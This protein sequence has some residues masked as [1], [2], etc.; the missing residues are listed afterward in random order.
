MQNLKALPIEFKLNSLKIVPS[1][2][3]EKYASRNY[4][5]F[6]TNHKQF[7]IKIYRNKNPKINAL[8]KDSDILSTKELTS[9]E[10]R[11]TKILTAIQN[12]QPEFWGV[13]VESWN[14]SFKDMIS[15]S[16]HAHDFDIL[17][18][19]LQ[20]A[21][22][23]KTARRKQVRLMQLT[24]D[25]IVMD[26]SGNFQL[27][28]LDNNLEIIEKAPEYV[29]SYVKY[30]SV[31]RKDSPLAPEVF[32]DKSFSTSS[33]V[34]DLGVLALKIFTAKHPKVDYHAQ[35]VKLDLNVK[36]T[37]SNSKRTIAE[38]IKG[39]LEFHP[40]QRFELNQLILMGQ[41][42]LSQIGTRLRDL[43]GRLLSKMTG[44]NIELGKAISNFGDLVVVDQ[45]RDDRVLVEF[46]P[47]RRITEVKGFT[48][49]KLVKLIVQAGSSMN[50]NAG[51]EL[52]KLAWNEPSSI[53]Q[54]YKEL[55]EK[56]DEISFNE[57]KSMKM[58]L[59][60]YAYLTKAGRNTLLV[61]GKA[62][63]SLNV[64]NLLLEKLMSPNMNNTQSIVFRM[65]HLMLIK[66]NV[67][68]K[69]LGVCEN[70]FAVSKGGLILDYQKLMTPE[71]TLELFDYLNFLITFFLANR[72]FSFDY[73][74]KHCVVT[75]FREI[76][77]VLGLLSNQILLLQFGITIFEKSKTEF[78]KENMVEFSSLITQ[79]LEALDRVILCL[80]IYIQQANRL[81]FGNLRA[82]KLKTNLTSY[83]TGVKERMS[84]DLADPQK[85]SLRLFTKNYMNNL[86]RMSNSTDQ[87]KVPKDTKDP[88]EEAAKLKVQFKEVL[89]RYLEKRQKFDKLI[90][91]SARVIP[92]GRFWFDYI[93]KKNQMRAKSSTPEGDIPANSEF[94]DTQ[95]SKLSKSVQTVSIGIQVDIAPTIIYKTKIEEKLV[96]QNKKH[97]FNESDSGIIF[98]FLLCSPSRLNNRVF[99]C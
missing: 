9:N 18:F 3:K 22:Y 85:F 11:P 77:S 92:K 1:G 42:S 48:P 53:V 91:D 25:L 55:D 32:Q 35:K 15:E 60:L 39:C 14:L 34:W 44:K 93:I 76:Q 4:L 2:K 7:Y 46:T 79:F 21:K 51:R 68:L 75:L 47:Q 8:L 5:I 66:F 95:S 20:I 89:T 29:D 59:F 31:K 63:G 72:K 61:Q 57:V 52:I 12:T 38:I 97:I 10:C 33:L 84:I 83:F 64:V 43:N 86:V 96:S 45:L 17:K 99:R 65:A 36:G 19:I 74:A 54:V 56:M 67:N 49:K 69:L 80:N 58:L 50:D 37:L 13:L 88:V 41:K 16:S 23:L 98:F 26:H 24:E 70:N 62:R 78:S 90:V 6:E 71:V 94:A 81:G 82:F 30:M 27:S 28:N 73:F 40:E 87:R